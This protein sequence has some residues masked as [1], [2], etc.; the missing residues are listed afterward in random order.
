MDSKICRHCNLEK[1]LSD[2]E[3]RKDVKGGK[4]HKCNQCKKDKVNVPLLEQK[5]HQTSK[6]S[7]ESIYFE[8]DPY[9][10]L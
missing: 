5:H 7:T 2:F 4:S 3:N 9:Y 8:H 10:Q 1:P 6:N